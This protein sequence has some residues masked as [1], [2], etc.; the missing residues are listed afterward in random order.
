MI[1][2]QPINQ[3]QLFGLDKFINELIN[4]YNRDKLPNK[5]LLSGQKGLGKS[6]MAYHFINYV[7]SKNEEFGYDKKNF[8]INPENRS[9]KTTINKSNPNLFLI[10]VNTEKTYID[11]AQI[12]NLITNLNKTSFNTKPK[13]ILIDN[14]E[15]LNIN[16]INSLLKILEEPTF[17]TH[18]ILINNNK[19]I[20]STLLSRCLNFKISLSNK[21][22]LIIANKLLK[23]KLHEYISDNLIN[24]Y[25]SPGDIYSLVYFS[26]QN[27]IDLSSCRLRDFIK[28]IID[29]KYYK[30]DHIIKNL[31][32][33]FIEF[34]FN[35]HNSSFSSKISD[36]YS[37]FIKKI[38]DTKKFNLDEETL[39][40]E[41][42]NR[43]LNE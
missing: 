30:K 28:I 41:F 20:L 10:D 33:N 34:Y 32:F 19:K 27:D 2:N 23:G 22:N 40:I 12:R 16:S 7:L 17:N 39:F 26:I 25:L 38:S 1:Q 37:Y 24:Y 31:F 6:T 43:M 36:K 42:E 14:I 18:F 13:F 11:I 21:E 15:F 3:I 4:L 5:I 8:I 35:N 9:F 29:N